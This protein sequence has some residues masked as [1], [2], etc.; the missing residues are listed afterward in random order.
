M[1]KL[2]GVIPSTDPTFS[3]VPFSN[4]ETSK[5]L[6]IAH[7]Q[8]VISSA[9]YN[10]IWQPYSSDVTA[11]DSRLSDF[12]R[13]IGASVAISR[14]KSNGKGRSADVWRSVTI[15]ALQ[16]MSATDTQLH[17]SLL[18]G[19]DTAFI[20]SSREYKLV[21]VVLSVL[22]PLLETS[23]LPQFKADLLE[24]AKQAISVWNYA[25]VDELTFNINPTLS[26]DNKHDWKVAALDYA[27]LYA[28]GGSSKRVGTSRP[29]NSTKIFTLFPIITATKRV[30]V[31][32]VGLG[33][34]GSWPDQ[35]KQQASNTEVTIIHG[36][37]GLSE[38]S[39]MVQR[40]MEEMEELKKMRLDHD[41]LW[42]KKLVGR[43][44]GHSRN[45]STADII[46]GPPS[47]SQSWGTNKLNNH[48]TGN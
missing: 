11:A 34:P 32:K 39:E 10:T 26:Q 23:G 47:P 31:Q 36:G 28:D 41:E 16:S 7:A 46:S 5:Q 17:Q 22:G 48:K 27:S 35:D 6:R 30:Q 37:L 14:H 38:D 21:E 40:G 12:L 19:Q 2:P 18:N 3:D 9:I 20:I 45:N 42:A 25:Q 44:K 13:E 1:A 24:I 8:R 43:H 15:R 29:R 33:P 4:S